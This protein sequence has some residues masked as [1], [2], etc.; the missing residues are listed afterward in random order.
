[1][2][3]RDFAEIGSDDGLLQEMG[4]ERT[5]YRTGIQ[6]LSRPISNENL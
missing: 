6:G 3:H 1:M 2:Q 4:D 5:G